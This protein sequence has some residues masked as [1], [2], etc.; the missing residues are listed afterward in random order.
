[1]RCAIFLLFIAFIE[2][3]KYFKNQSKKKLSDYDIVILD[4]KNQK[5]RKKETLAM[6]LKLLHKFLGLTT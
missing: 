5:L 4:P 6:Q 2:R 1:M 3:V